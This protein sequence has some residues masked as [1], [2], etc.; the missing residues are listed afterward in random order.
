[1]SERGEAPSPE[2]REAGTFDCEQC[3]GTFAKT[4]SDE[5]AKAEATQLWA[6]EIEAG[7]PMVV[8]CDD[9]HKEIVERVRDDEAGR[10]R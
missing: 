10:S 9:C 4:W 6:G 2:F 5:E 3:G 8:V 7:S 1:M